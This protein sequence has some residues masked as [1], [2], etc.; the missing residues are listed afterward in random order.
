MSLV[1]DQNDQ[2]F[3]NTSWPECPEMGTIDFDLPEKF[4]T[5]QKR[6]EKEPT[7]DDDLL[8]KSAPE[9]IVSDNEL[10]CIGPIVYSDQSDDID[11]DDDQTVCICIRTTH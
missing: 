8:D 11:S 2:Q 1:Q 4:F 6:N 9:L 7:S 10:E 5:Q 3:V